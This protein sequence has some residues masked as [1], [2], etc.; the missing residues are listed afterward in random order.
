MSLSA[1][2]ILNACCEYYPELLKVSVLERWGVSIRL[3]IKLLGNSQTFSD[4]WP[5]EGQAIST[6]KDLSANTP[7]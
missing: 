1:Y 4:D 5:G 3:N 7:E 2:T 6:K